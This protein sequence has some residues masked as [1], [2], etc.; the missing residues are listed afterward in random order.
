MLMLDLFFRSFKDIVNLSGEV[1]VQE[2][3]GL[4]KTNGVNW[5]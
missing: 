5:E 2:L 1:T 3:T 4:K